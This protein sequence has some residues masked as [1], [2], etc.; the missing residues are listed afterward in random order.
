M[1]LC[2]GE[3]VEM[4]MV[5]VVVPFFEYGLVEWSQPFE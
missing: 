1:N 2:G 4:V 5:T 3:G